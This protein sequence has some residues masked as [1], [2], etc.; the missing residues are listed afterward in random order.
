MILVR[1]DP[2][3]FWPQGGPEP[4]ICSKYGFSLKI[5]WKL[6]DLEEF[7][8]ARGPSGSAS[9]SHAGPRPG[10]SLH[11]SA[12]NLHLCIRFLSRRTWLCQ[13]LLQL[14]AC[15]SL[16]CK[17]L[18]NICSASLGPTQNLGL[19]IRRRDCVNTAGACVVCPCGF[20]SPS[21]PQTNA[22]PNHFLYMPSSHFPTRVGLGPPLDLRPPVLLY[23]MQYLQSWS[24]GF[25]WSSPEFVPVKYAGE[26]TL[27][28]LF[29]SLS[30]CSP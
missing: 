12:L 11:S 6:H 14:P 9:A 15:V 19:C 24:G 5:V 16:Y 21:V 29:V 25:S 26:S 10:K 8:G 27:L 7:L 18:C 13:L 30:V 22:H 20:V 2:A 3:E 23:L 17:I 28:C 4:K 1:R